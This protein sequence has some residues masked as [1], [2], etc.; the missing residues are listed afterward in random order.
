M[1]HHTEAS[2]TRCSC[3]E[4]WVV[5]NLAEEGVDVT[6]VITDPVVPFSLA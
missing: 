4:A 3:N 2:M 1:E 5:A 6:P